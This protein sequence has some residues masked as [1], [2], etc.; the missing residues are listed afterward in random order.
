[1]HIWACGHAHRR[2]A[3]LSWLPCHGGWFGLRHRVLPPVQSAGYVFEWLTLKAYEAR[4]I[5]SAKQGSSNWTIQR[6]LTD[7]LMHQQRML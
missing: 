4:L 2:V 6:T 1:M 5:E 7:S 3:G